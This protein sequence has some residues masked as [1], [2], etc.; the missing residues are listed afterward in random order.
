MKI[1][2]NEP[3]HEKWEGMIPNKEG[4]FCN[5]CAKDVVDFSKMGIK[6]IK[7]F[8][9]KPESSENVCGRFKETQLQELSFD[10]F[11]SKFTYWNSTKKFAVIFFMAFG[12]WIFS[13]SDAMAQKE[14]TLQGKVSYEPAKNPK[15]DSAK[16]KDSKRPK[17]P[18]GPKGIK[19]MGKVK[20][21]NPEHN[22]QA[23][24][25]EQMIMGDIAP[26][27]EDKQPTPKKKEE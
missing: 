20:C 5:S 19:T 1:S 3:C 18:K 11:F 4:A 8:F 9:S 23:V 16:V 24:K 2:I 14:Q 10:D 12:F 15:S 25:K 13:S 7:S 22:K 26:P 6:Q 27:N 17:N 21:D